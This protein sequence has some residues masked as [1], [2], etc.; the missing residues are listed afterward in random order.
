MV[1]SSHILHQS[2]D[3]HLHLSWEAHLICRFPEADS[4]FAE[5]R[6][7]EFLLL[8]SPCLVLTEHPE[9]LGVKSLVLTPASSCHQ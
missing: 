6:G 5:V 4:S 2:Q 3:P 8:S 1:L 9:A 7:Q